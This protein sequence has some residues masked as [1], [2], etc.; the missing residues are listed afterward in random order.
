MPLPGDTI[1]YPGHGPDSTIS[2][3]R[4][5]KPVPERAVLGGLSGPGAPSLTNSVGANAILR[6]LHFC[7]KKK[8]NN[9]DIITAM[10]AQIHPFPYFVIAVGL[11]G[12]ITAVRARS[13]YEIKKPLIPLKT[14]QRLCSG[15]LQI[16]VL[17]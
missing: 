11:L 9:D 2:D 4:I 6:V 3:E 8:Y 10:V 5:D 7:T 16:W 14:L 1:V 13:R 17:P 12:T 15:T